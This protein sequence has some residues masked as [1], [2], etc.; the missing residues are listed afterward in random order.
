MP[1]VS[2]VSRVDIIGRL[3][4]RAARL[5]NEADDENDRCGG[6]VARAR[7]SRLDVPAYLSLDVV[8]A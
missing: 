8:C 6:V 1:A 5:R 4:D 3:P 2:I 7:V